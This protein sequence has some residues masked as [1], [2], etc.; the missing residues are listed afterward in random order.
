MQPQGWRICTGHRKDG[1][2]CE[3]AA[4]TGSDKC[5][6]HLG[7]KAGPVAAAAKAE[8]KAARIMATYGLPIE[9]NATQALIDEVQRTA[10]HV[11]WLAQRVRELDTDPANLEDPDGSVRAGNG[12]HPLVWGVTRIK[13]G[14]HDG[15]ITEEAQPSIWLK[16]YQQERAHLVRVCAE[17]IKAG[18]DERMVR[19]AE[20]QGRQIAGVIRGILE[21]LVLTPEQ[22]ARV[23]EIVPR[24]LRAVSA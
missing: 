7:K 12:R 18:V 11:E 15:G 19:L 2:P 22:Q 24:R 5:R 6:M 8:A 4:V 13:E 23:R 9:T 1:L 3:G 14:G 16:L 21:D 10:G 20:E 17:S